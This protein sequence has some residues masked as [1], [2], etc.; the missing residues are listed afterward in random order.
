M[1]HLQQINTYP[2][3]LGK[4]IPT[5]KKIQTNMPPFGLPYNPHYSACFFSRNSIFLLQQFSQNSVFQPIQP[6]RSSVSLARGGLRKW[7][8]KGCYDWNV[9][10]S[11]V[12]CDWRYY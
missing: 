7:Q 9:T 4:T 6:L 11:H 2:T 3:T 12:R 8:S 5:E 1:Y 10:R